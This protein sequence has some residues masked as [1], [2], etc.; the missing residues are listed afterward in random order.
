MLERSG[1][2]QQPLKQMKK[3]GRAWRDRNGMRLWGRGEGKVYVSMPRKY[4]DGGLRSQ[5]RDWI[6]FLERIR[7][8]ARI[9][10]MQG[11]RACLRL[12]PAVAVC[13]SEAA[14][15]RYLWS[16]IVNEAS[17]PCD[18]NLQKRK[19]NQQESGGRPAFH[20]QIDRGGR[21]KVP[22]SF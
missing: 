3:I 21:Y 7:P 9:S 15:R 2:N 13:L 20:S 5:E 4:R 8:N 19:S 18:A 11:L 6:D 14:R 22:L 10:I 12:R 16:G 1:L 17:G